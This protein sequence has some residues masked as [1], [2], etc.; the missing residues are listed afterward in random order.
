MKIQLSYQYWY[1]CVCACV[2]AWACMCVSFSLL[3]CNTGSEQAINLKLLWKW[4][5]LGPEREYSG[6][7]ISA[8]NYVQGCHAE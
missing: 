4:L 7:S 6:A 5:C 8:C 1:V 3:T 2:H